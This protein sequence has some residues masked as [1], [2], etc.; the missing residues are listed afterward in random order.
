MSMYACHERSMRPGAC[1]AASK[2]DMDEDVQPIGI[3]SNIPRGDAA[4]DAKTGADQLY[5]VTME[6]ATKVRSACMLPCAAQ[7]ALCR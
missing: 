1:R 6:D 5:F 2:T 7:C 3:P 4:N